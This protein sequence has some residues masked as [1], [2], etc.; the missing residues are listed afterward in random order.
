MLLEPWG[1]RG[2]IRRLGE[3]DVT[4]LQV[5]NEDPEIQHLTGKRLAKGG[6]WWNELLRDRNRVA[7]GIVNTAREL[8]GDVELEQIVWR[9]REAELRIAIGDKRYWG[10][11]YGSEAVQAVLETAFLG[12]GLHRVYLRVK[13]E[14]GRAMQAYRKAGFRK[15]GRLI[16]NGRLQGHG[17]LILM[18]IDRHTYGW[19]NEVVLNDDSAKSDGRR[20]TPV[21]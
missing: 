13:P 3:D 11:G 18:E 2:R 8:I 17:D 21:V 15:V 20:L 12:L 16:G 1:S 9:S 14:N 19:L 7:F 5:W 6:T 4:K 10:M